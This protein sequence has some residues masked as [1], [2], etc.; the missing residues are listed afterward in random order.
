[1]K[2]DTEHTGHALT[3]II[4]SGAYSSIPFCVNHYC[5]G[6]D[7]DFKSPIIIGLA[8]KF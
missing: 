1:M 6:I 2:Q 7:R 3:V 5:L 8:A 4:L